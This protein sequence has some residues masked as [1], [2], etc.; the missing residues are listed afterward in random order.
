[1]LTLLEKEWNRLD[2]HEKED[3]DLRSIAL[4]QLILEMV[5]T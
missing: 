1:M 2:Q 3:W 4:I 5:G